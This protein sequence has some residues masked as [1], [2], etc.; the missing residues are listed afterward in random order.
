MGSPGRQNNTMVGREKLSQLDKVFLDFF[1]VV[2][3]KCVVLV[4]L[5]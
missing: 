3:I 1:G 2:Y 5:E 4:S